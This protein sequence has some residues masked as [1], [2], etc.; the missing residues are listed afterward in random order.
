MTVMTVSCY[1]YYV[2]YV[3]N[4]LDRQ[5][6]PC[7]KRQSAASKRQVRQ[8]F[9]VSWLPKNAWIWGKKRGKKELEKG[10]SHTLPYLWTNV[11]TKLAAINLEK[12]SEKHFYCTPMSSIW[13]VLSR[14]GASSVRLWWWYRP[15]PPLCVQLGLHTLHTMHSLIWHKAPRK[16]VWAT[17]EA[18]RVSE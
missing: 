4:I 11:R 14:K 6:W 7:G 8:S 1:L 12:R 10:G 5:Y 2:L 15:F 13:P 18:V 3:R 9:P 16:N 17:L